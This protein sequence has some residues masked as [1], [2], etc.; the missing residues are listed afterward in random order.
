MGEIKFDHNNHVLILDNPL[1]NSQLYLLSEHT[2]FIHK[3][4]Y[5]REDLKSLL[6][7]YSRIEQDE[8]GNSLLYYDNQCVQI[9]DFDKIQNQS[10]RETQ[11]EFLHR[12]HS[13]VDYMYSTGLIIC[14]KELKLLRVHFSNQILTIPIDELRAIINTKILH[15]SNANILPFSSRHLSQW[16]LNNCDRISNSRQDCIQL[17]YKNQLYILPS[18][19]SNDH[20]ENID[21]NLILL[22][23]DNR[24]L[25]EIQK[26][27]STTTLDIQQPNET[28]GYAIDP[29][30]ILANYVYRAGT[31]YQDALG[32]LVI[33]LNKDE[34]VV[35]HI[36]AINSIEAINTAPNRTGTIIARLID[37]LGKVRSNK[38]G[39]IIITIGKRS[40][41]LSKETIDRS[42]HYYN[43]NIPNL[44]NQ[45]TTSI[46]RLS[47][48][49]PTL[50]LLQHSKSVGSLSSS[51]IGH[52]RFTDDQQMLYTKDGR[53]DARYL[54]LAYANHLENNHQTLKPRFIIIPSDETTRFYIQYTYEQRFYT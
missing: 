30:L 11:T 12:Y 41:E 13:I 36:E 3:N 8:S 39:G 49:T 29:L 26:T 37:R 21:P 33:K 23:P 16:L 43:G 54:N 52:S 47:N 14:N 9:P 42:N 48:S 50:P 19:P 44:R 22:F 10:S 46:V 17:T 2:Q 7:K 6:K 45:R 53:G 38:A 34:I 31:I 51:S 28:N 5:R 24:D 1:D 32:R 40:I 20:Q 18:I 35:P 4:Q 27:A 25:R 15:S